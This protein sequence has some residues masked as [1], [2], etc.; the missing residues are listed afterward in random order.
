MN[1]RYLDS[2]ES[3]VEKGKLYWQKVWNEAKANKNVLIVK[4][5]L[6]KMTK[7]YYI[8]ALHDFLN[9][10][11]NEKIDFLTANQEN[12]ILFTRKM[13]RAMKAYVADLLSNLSFNK[14]FDSSMYEEM[15]LDFVVEGSVHLRENSLKTLYNFGNPDSIVKAYILMSEKEISHS[16]KLLS[17]GLI[18]SKCDKTA[19]AEK[20]V[21]NID[22]FVD[23]YKIAT[24]NSLFREN[25]HS[26]DSDFKKYVLNNKVS[27]DFTCA[28]FRLITKK[29]DAEN[30]EF[31]SDYISSHGDEEYWEEKTVAAG[32]LGS[33]ERTDKIAGVLCNCLTDRNWYIRMNSAKSLC[34]IGITDEEKAA[35][36]NSEDKY[37]KEALAYA[38]SS[39]KEA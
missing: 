10:I 16:E 36:N 8:V 26:F 22:K 20:L 37:A 5:K 23:C 7:P 14:K 1:G 25:N 24:I 6:K 18:A 38:L 17:D 27:A 9:S 2:F 19:L 12:F 11:K 35:I 29:P 4:N 21:E 31:I 3:N 32:C 39:M 30:G 34:H 13:N 33:Y 28:V 15:M